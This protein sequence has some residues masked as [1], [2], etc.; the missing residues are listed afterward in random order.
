MADLSGGAGGVS[1]DLLGLW[2][3]FLVSSSMHSQ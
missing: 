3:G 1:R 2:E